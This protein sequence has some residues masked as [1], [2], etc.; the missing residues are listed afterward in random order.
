MGGNQRRQRPG[1]EFS[2]DLR[3]L[4]MTAE[5]KAPTPLV[6]K[7][8]VDAAYLQPI[9][10][11]PATEE[12][13]IDPAP[14]EKKL[15]DAALLRPCFGQRAVAGSD[16]LSGFNS[17]QDSRRL[18]PKVLRIFGLKQIV[19]LLHERIAMFQKPLVIQ[20]FLGVIN[21]DSR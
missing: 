8:Q 2:G 20:V 18:S 12:P 1:G 11:L 4:D 5:V 13:I 16:R 6:E 7:T 17:F 14:V 3:I 10:S 15:S 21:L 19:D 9:C